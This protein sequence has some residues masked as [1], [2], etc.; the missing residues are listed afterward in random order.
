M[1]LVLALC[2]VVIAFFVVY[3]IMSY[4]SRHAVQ[5]RNHTIGML[6]AESMIEEVRSHDFGSPPPSSWPLANPVDDDFPTVVEGATQQMHFHKKMDL[7][8]GSFV[9]QTDADSDTVTLTVTWDELVGPNSPQAMQA[10]QK[11]RQVTAQ[12]LVRRPQLSD[13]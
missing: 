1:E 3:S 6:V 2:V 11:Q 4:S 8:N 12:I 13:Q 10:Q 5:S 9:G 7:A